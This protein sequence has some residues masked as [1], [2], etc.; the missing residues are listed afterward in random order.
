MAVKSLEEVLFS[1][2]Q[3]ESNAANK[4]SQFSKASKNPAVQKVF[5]TT[6]LAER[7]HAEKM[8]KLALRSSLDMT[9]F[10]PQLLDVEISD[11]KSNLE[12]AI[13]GEV[14]ESTILYPQLAEVMMEQQ[15]KLVSTTVTSLGKVEVEHAKLFELIKDKFLNT[16][17]EIV[18]YLCP[19]CGNIYLEKFPETCDTCGGSSKMFQKY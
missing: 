10:I 8:R 17:T 5:S 18:L 15:N 12:V 6:A 2:F 14:Y 1:I 4:Y 19:N 3:G 9:K 13:K 16:N 7:I 11:D